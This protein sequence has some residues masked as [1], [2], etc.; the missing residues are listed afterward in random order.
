[1][2]APRSVEDRLKRLTERV[3]SGCL[4]WTGSL[5]CDGYGKVSVKIRGKR[6]SLAH[7]MVYR[8]F[9]GDIP[10]ECEID[11][12][13]RNRSCVNPAHLRA[14]SHAENVARSVKD[15]AN[16]RN[17]RKTHCKRGHPLSGEN[18]IVEIWRGRIARKC[19]ACRGARTDAYRMKR[20]TPRSI[21][22]REI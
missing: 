13:C 9:V 12:I 6:E 5:C 16:H 21:R 3:G 17:T 22:I 10:E 15:P 7:R 2:P 20:K 18:L 4:V 11:H 8:H 19:R 1:M 14:V